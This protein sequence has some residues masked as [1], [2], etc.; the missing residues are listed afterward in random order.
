[1]GFILTPY[2]ERENPIYGRLVVA[3]SRSKAVEFKNEVALK[4]YSTQK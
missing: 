2:E 1:M 4:E 3:D